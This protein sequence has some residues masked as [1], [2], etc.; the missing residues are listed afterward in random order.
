MKK[1][2]NING[3]IGLLDNCFAVVIL[4]S[5]TD[6]IL[7]APPLFCPFKRKTSTARH[8][9]CYSRI[10]QNSKTRCN[11]NLKIINKDVVQITRSHH[12]Q[13]EKIQ[14][15][16]NINSINP[17]WN[18]SL[19]GTA[20]ISNVRPE[21]TIADFHFL[22]H[23]GAGA[24]GKVVS[25]VLNGSNEVCAV[26]ILK[27]SKSD[28]MNDTIINNEKHILIKVAAHPFLIALHSTFEQR[29]KNYYLV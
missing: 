20:I 8:H 4:V 15:L 29:M 18:I 17:E 6:Q 9:F 25:A 1:K 2:Y 28:T 3:Q 11:F 23:L 19:C 24:F 16:M 14:S 21:T 10:D 5:S 7:V 27:K 26:K 12:Q 13:C 22:K